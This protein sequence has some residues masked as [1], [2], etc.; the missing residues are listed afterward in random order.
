MSDERKL[1]EECLAMAMA[2]QNVIHKTFKDFDLPL[3]R[4]LQDKLKEMHD[5]HQ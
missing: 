4:Q 5:V 1:L 2:M 3:V